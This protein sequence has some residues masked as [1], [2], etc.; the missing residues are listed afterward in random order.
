[1]IGQAGT[2]SGLDWGI[3][4]VG[5]L[6]LFVISYVFGREEKDTNDFFLG[7][8]RVP[9]AVAC[10]SFVA[11]EISALT[12]VGIPH[13]AYTENWRFL[14]FLV[15]LALAR[16]V[17][18]FLFIPAFYK[19]NCTSIYEFLGHRFGPATQYTGSIYFFITR[20]I[21]SGVRLYAT[22]MAVGI[23][24]DWSLATSITL[25]TI[26]SIVFIAFGGI[27]AVV[28]AG[29][30]QALFF[31]IAGVMIVGYLIQHIEGGLA[32]AMQTANDA[33]RLS[34]FYFKFDLK[35]ASTFWAFLISGFFI[36]LVSFGTDQEMVQ[37]LLTVDTRKSSQKTIIST[38]FTVL[39]VYWL[40]LLV[41]TL[42][43]VFYQNS[44][45]SLPPDK[46]KEILPH[47]ARNVLPNGLK[48]MVLGAIFLAS[49]DS[50]LSSLSSSFVTDI[51]RPL[52]RRGASEKHYLLVSRAAVVGFGLVL[53]GIAL[54][55]A[56][57]K[58]ILWF[59]FQILSI[60]GGPMLGAFLLGL[61]TKRK[62]NLANIPA[63]LFSTLVCI[64]LLLLIKQEIIKFAWSWL[65]V[66]GTGI[67]FFIGYLLGPVMMRSKD[68]ETPM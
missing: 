58:N 23:I 63:M 66:I 7:G 45:L 49:V 3:V 53:A 56:P 33:E 14:Q 62:A 21:A 19:H 65:I 37:R 29:A 25:F 9:P 64:V 8:R 50:P 39:P 59:A 15:G 51:Y 12:I 38:I 1:M 32:A 52:I 13:T 48:G 36:G 44:S 4:C 57:V 31:V 6:G 68:T 27:K 30:Y 20:L 28:W 5:A 24:M 43:F 35:D 60:T 18:S 61:L 22:C 2:L 16:L 46:F 67:T 17:V 47:F 26:I 42:L 40:Y 41:G 54:A 11:A 55:C 34:T 10:L